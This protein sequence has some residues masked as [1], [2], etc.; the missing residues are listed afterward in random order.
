MFGIARPGCGFRLDD[1]G[2]PSPA[3]NAE[4]YV[5]SLALTDVTLSATD[6][7][8]SGTPPCPVICTFDGL[9]GAD[10]SDPAADAGAG[11]E[12]PLPD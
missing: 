6:S 2:T 1:D 12:H 10:R 5:L 8:P 11:V 4:K 7:A 9:V 3:G